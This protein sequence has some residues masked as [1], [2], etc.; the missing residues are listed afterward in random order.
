MEFQNSFK[1]I[2]VDMLTNLLE[3]NLRL[4]FV[5]F[6]EFLI[7][8]I[9]QNVMQTIKKSDETWQLETKQ[10]PLWNAH[11]WARV[12]RGWIFPDCRHQNYLQ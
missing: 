10:E 11:S 5:K 3:L 1:G 12:G 7:G 9:W 6:L 2:Q 4:I 8:I